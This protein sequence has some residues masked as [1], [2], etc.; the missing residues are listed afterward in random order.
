M[1]DSSFDDDGDGC[2][3]DD[4][5]CDDNNLWVYPTATEDC[6]FIDNDC[7]GLEDEGAEDEELGAC[8]YEV[9]QTK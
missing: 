9:V 1:R 7:D 2:S 4:G 3:E 5:D 8:I 6:D